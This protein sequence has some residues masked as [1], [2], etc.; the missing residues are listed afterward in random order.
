MDIYSRLINREN[1]LPENFVPE[2]LVSCE[3][4]FL[5]AGSEEK[6]LLCSAAAESARRLIEYGKSFGCHL[7]GISGYRSYARQQEIYETRLREAGPE[8]VS[9]FLA[10]PGASEHQSGLAL[11]VSCPSVHM[12]LDENFAETREGR[13]LA[14]YAPMFGFILRYPRGKEHIT[15]YAWEPWHIRYVSKSLALYLALTGL[16]LEEYHRI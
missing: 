4:P 3:F 5:A 8:H 11:D 16:T 13:W 14:A 15:G 2:D 7:A 12:E 6:R 10:P 1:P 9:R